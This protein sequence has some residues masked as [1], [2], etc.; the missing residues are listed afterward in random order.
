MNKSVIK[1]VLVV[2]LGV[3]TSGFC[4]G[5]TIYYSSIEECSKN[6]KRCYEGG[7]RSTLLHC[8]DDYYE[9]GQWHSPPNCNTTTCIIYACK[10]AEDE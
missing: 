9:N 10:E 2:I 1:A 7:C 5:E 3:V 6:H 4:V 8:G